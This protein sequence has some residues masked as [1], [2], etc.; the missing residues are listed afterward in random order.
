MTQVSGKAL[1]DA[2]APPLHH[3]T[4]AHEHPSA[5]KAAH[6][7]MP[8]PVAASRDLVRSGGLPLPTALVPN[9]H[10]L[11]EHHAAGALAFYVQMGWPLEGSS[12]AWQPEAFEAWERLHAKKNAG[13]NEAAFRADGGDRAGDAERAQQGKRATPEVHQ[14]AAGPGR[15]VGHKAKTPPQPAAPGGT[16]A[17]IAG[18][19]DLVRS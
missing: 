10:L 18:S 7:A 12:R 19:R 16:A 15:T 2:R 11:E 1:L 6:E 13:Q 14:I 4:P 8:P 5:N 9:P 3:A 17:P